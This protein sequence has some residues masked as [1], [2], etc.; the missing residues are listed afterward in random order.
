[1]KSNERNSLYQQPLRNLF[2]KLLEMLL[3]ARNPYWRG[4]LCTVN[5][6][7]NVASLVKKFNINMCLCVCLFTIK[8][9]CS[10]LVGVGR[11]TV[12]IFPLQQVF[13]ALFFIVLTSALSSSS[14]TDLWRS[15]GTMTFRM[16]TLCRTPF[17]MLTGS[18]ITFSVLTCSR[19]LFY[20]LTC[21]RI[22]FSALTC[23]RGVT[24]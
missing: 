4:T 7:V 21:S 14:L 20:I 17:Y 22:T 24:K 1:M 18:R 16:T 12:L 5:L 8:R 6:L 2:G 23:S 11:S 3:S 19:T 10:K 13:P 9:S 15:F